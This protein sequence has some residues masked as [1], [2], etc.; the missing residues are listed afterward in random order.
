[1]RFAEQNAF[2]W[3]VISL[4]GGGT[5][6]LACLWC[7]QTLSATSALLLTLLIG[8]AAWLL[9]VQAG[10]NATPLTH[11]SNPPCGLLKH[12]KAE[13]EF[14]MPGNSWYLYSSVSECQSCHL[15]MYCHQPSTRLHRSYILHTAKPRLTHFVWPAGPI[16]VIHAV[17]LVIGALLD[18]HF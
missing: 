1:M 6:L 2:H 14:E 11:P 3:S 13:G 18:R 15:P 10:Q 12:V 4:T 17:L 9:H 16:T 7:L 8:T 5:C